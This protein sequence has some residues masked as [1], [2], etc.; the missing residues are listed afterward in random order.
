MTEKFKNRYRIESARLRNYDYGKNGA[1]FVTICTKDRQ[2]FFGE[3]IHNKM[4]LSEIG[5]L[6]NEYW[7]EIPE[8][9]PFVKLGA[10]IAM[11]NHIHGIVIIDKNIYCR[12]CNCRYD[13]HGNGRCRHCRNVACNV[14]TMTTTTTKTT[15][16]KN[17][18]MA[19]ISPKPGSLSTIIRSYKSAVSKSA[20][21]LNDQFGWQPRFHDHIIRN[22]T[23]YNRIENYIINNPKK[24]N[25]DR[26]RMK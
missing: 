17:E 14:S 5:N 23:D 3:I 11:P 7:Y 19:S 9:F 12:D 25:E 13:C 18:H 10:F 20:H 22:K 24:W 2:H 6:T 21:I 26:F 16:Q 8:H 1:Y 4:I 15:T